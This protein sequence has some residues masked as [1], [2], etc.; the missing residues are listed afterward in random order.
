LAGYVSAFSVVVGVI[1]CALA[2]ISLVW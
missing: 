1:G 2:V